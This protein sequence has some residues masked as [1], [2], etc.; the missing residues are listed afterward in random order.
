MH[1]PMT[2]PL[3]RLRQTARLAL[4]RAAS[5]HRGCGAGPG[6]RRAAGQGRPPAHEWRQTAD[7]V[8][9]QRHP[10]PTA[11]P[12]KE[13]PP[14]GVFTR[15]APVAGADARS[16]SEKG[17]KVLMI[18]D[19]HSWLLMPRSQRPA[20]RQRPCENFRANASTGDIATMALGLRRMTLPWWAPNP[21]TP[22]SRQ[23]PAGICTASTPQ[24]SGC[25]R[26]GLSLGGN[27]CGEG[28]GACRP[29]R[30]V[31]QAGR[32]SAVCGGPAGCAPARWPPKMVLSDQVGDHKPTQI[33]HLAAAEE[34][35]NSAGVAERDA[36]GA[37]PGVG[38]RRCSVQCLPRPGAGQHA[39][40]LPRRNAG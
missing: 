1:Y 21:A 3:R 7:R 39:S 40:A 37:Q 5:G 22:P 24:R 27:P 15:P 32:A 30:A 11:A 18:G 26:V 4:L 2:H 8:P 9:G 23:P 35:Q 33:R 13:T 34:R 14:P 29:V 19:E 17:R 16:P 38:L 28:R 6:R 36:S 31:R 20:A 12:T 10:R 25:E